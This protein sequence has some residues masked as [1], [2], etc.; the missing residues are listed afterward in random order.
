MTGSR[1]T[2]R[3]VR[4]ERFDGGPFVIGEFVA[5]DSRLQFGSLNHAPGY[6][7]NPQR[8]IASD[9][10]ILILL[11]AEHSGCCRTCYLL[12]PVANDPDFIIGIIGEPLTPGW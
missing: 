5:H 1:Q 10:N 12:A 11:P 3:L 9:A 7:I 2:A 6:A 8:A 4:Q